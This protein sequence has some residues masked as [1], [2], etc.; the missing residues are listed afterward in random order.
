MEGGDHSG[1]VH[2]TSS[3]QL[4]YNNINSKRLRL[5]HHQ[6]SNSS[7]ASIAMVENS[8]NQRLP[9]LS[10]GA[11]RVVIPTTATA[12]SVPI[13][14]PQVSVSNSKKDGDDGAMASTSAGIKRK[15]DV[16]SLPIPVAKKN[17]V[18]K[19]KTVAS[20][21]NRVEDDER[22]SL[23]PFA[24]SKAK[25]LSKVE[26]EELTG[27]LKTQIRH[28]LTS[29]FCEKVNP[30]SLR[31]I[32]LR[33]KLADAATAVAIKHRSIVAVTEHKK[34][35]AIRPSTGTAA[36]HLRRKVVPV[37]IKTTAIKLAPPKTIIAVEKRQQATNPDLLESIFSAQKKLFDRKNDSASS[38]AEPPA[39]SMAKD[40]PSFAV[41]IKQHEKTISVKPS[42]AAADHLRQKATP[43]VSINKSAPLQTIER[44]AA[45][46]IVEISVPFEGEKALRIQHQRRQEQ[47]RRRRLHIEITARHQ[48]SAVI[49]LMKQVG[50]GFSSL[51][52]LERRQFVEE[53]MSLDHIDVVHRNSSLPPGD[54]TAREKP[55]YFL[56][57]SSP[58]LSFHR[59]I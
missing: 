48:S 39:A 51:T 46:K 11:D 6:I 27:L 59:N 14:L 12:Y 20:S 44:P 42:N 34:T 43:A 37:P 32:K 56:Y 36:D 35:A 21:S 5:N 57:R 54:F 47:E 24:D 17:K 50:D 33:L 8:S 2:P 15:R 41:T 55:K 13:A 45:E 53:K 26:S 1:A 38:R 49:S 31:S 40:N 52:P 30:S 9:L 22:R 58:S 25:T 10:A 19:S 23:K 16:D 18:T 4:D 29:K 3:Q 7:S 28:D